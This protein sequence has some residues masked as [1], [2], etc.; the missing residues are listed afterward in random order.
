M[1]AFKARP[2]RRDD[3]RVYASATE[4]AADVVGDQTNITRACRNPRRTAYGYRWEYA[5]E[6]AGREVTA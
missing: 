3:G 4:A 6:A 2:V 5:D 1:T